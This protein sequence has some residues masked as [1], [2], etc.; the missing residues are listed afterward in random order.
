LR[1]CTERLE[2]LRRRRQAEQPQAPS[3]S[4]HR[5]PPVQR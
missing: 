2:P 4:R 5:R 3:Q 1:Q